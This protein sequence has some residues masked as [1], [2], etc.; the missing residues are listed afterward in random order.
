[1]KRYKLVKA[2]YLNDLED[3]VNTAI[4]E[5]Y[6]PIGAPFYDDGDWLQAVYMR[7]VKTV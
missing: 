7:E 5:G 6:E 1:M 2:I 4:S 3:M